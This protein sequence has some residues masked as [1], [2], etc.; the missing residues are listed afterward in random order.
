VSDWPVH[1]RRVFAVAVFEYVERPPA[2][3]AR[4]RYEYAALRA[5]PPS[6]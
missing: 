5:S 2:L 6:T 3:K 4:T 1:F